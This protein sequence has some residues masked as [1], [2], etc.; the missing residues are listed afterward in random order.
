MWL[1][2]FFGKPDDETSF[3]ELYSNFDG[4][5]RTQ[6]VAMWSDGTLSNQLMIAFFVFATAMKDSDASQIF[7]IHYQDQDAPWGHA[8]LGTLSEPML[9][10]NKPEC[11]LLSETELSAYRDIWLRY[12][13]SDPTKHANLACDSSI[14]ALTENAATSILRRY[15]SRSSGLNE[16]EEMLLQAA[17]HCCEGQPVVAPR[18]IGHVL[19]HDNSRDMVGDLYLFETLKKLGSSEIPMPL[20]KLTFNGDE[21][22]MR[23]CLVEVLPAASDVLHG[24]KNFV[25]IN[26]ID[27]WIGGVHLTMD[28]YCWREDIAA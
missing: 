9:F 22:H 28:S 17:L 27:S 3:H 8:R 18:I 13:S 16:L 6:T 4:S 25:A 21:Y 5:I 10:A 15:P 24:I 23:N 14:Q 11:Q 20:L 1:D 26:G 19:G 12:C 7:R 2:D